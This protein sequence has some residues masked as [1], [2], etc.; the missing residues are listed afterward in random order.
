[1]GRLKYAACGACAAGIARNAVCLSDIAR[2]RGSLPGNLDQSMSS[3]VI[4]SANARNIHAATMNCVHTPSAVSLYALTLAT[5]IWRSEAVA[6]SERVMLERSC[7]D[8]YLC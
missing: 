7:G 3:R 4:I 1:M 2:Q 8:C 5:N 6:A